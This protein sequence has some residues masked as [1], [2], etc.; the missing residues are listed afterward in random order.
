[1]S[2]QYPQAPTTLGDHLRQKRL[3]LKLLQ[4]D[5][6]KILGTN[7]DTVTYWENNRVEPS[8]DFLPKIINFLRYVPLGI[9]P[10]E[11]RRK[12]VTYRRLLGCRH[13][14]LARKLEI[15]P[16]TLLRWENGRRLSKEIE[17]RIAASYPEMIGILSLE[18]RSTY[19]ER[20]WKDGE[21]NS[22]GTE[23]LLDIDQTESPDISGS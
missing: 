12:L 13:D 20:S 6:A 16:G 11:H 19:R 18:W 3:D 23:T 2:D 5:V 8:L 10:D 4:K 15:D 22:Q 9:I 7:T 14:E 17:Q 1:M 21:V